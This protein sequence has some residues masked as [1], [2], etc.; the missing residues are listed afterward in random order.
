MKTF[1]TKQVERKFGEILELMPT[2]YSRNVYVEKVKAL[3]D[4]KIVSEDGEY[5]EYYVTEKDLMNL[6]EEMVVA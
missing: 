6:A 1:K 2:A 3:R 4:A 5:K